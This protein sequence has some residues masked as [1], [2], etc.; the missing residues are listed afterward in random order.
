MTAITPD[1][2]MYGWEMLPSHPPSQKPPYTFISFQ[3]K[4]TTPWRN[5]SVALRYLLLQPKLSHSYQQ[6]RFVDWNK[7]FIPML[8]GS[9][10][11]EKRL[12]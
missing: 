2:H 7:I 5:T 4:G 8:G 9:D 10:K 11:R 6:G 3:I 12:Y 1:L